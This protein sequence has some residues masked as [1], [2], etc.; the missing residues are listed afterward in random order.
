MN[1]QKATDDSIQRDS[2]FTYL[3][4]EIFILILEIYVTV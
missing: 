3:L 1:Y 4:F 2:L